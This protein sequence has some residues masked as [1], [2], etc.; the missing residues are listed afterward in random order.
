M[1]AHD[2]KRAEVR[3][4]RIREY[5]KNDALE[6]NA[7]LERLLQQRD[8]RRLLWWLL[9]IGRVS[10]QPFRADPYL[11]AFG[12]GEMNVGNQIQA[13]IIEASPTGYMNMQQEHADDD[14]TR[15]NSI[16]AGE[17]DPRSGGSPGGYDNPDFDDGDDTVE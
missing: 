11:T 8:G 15:S 1:A 6:I 3:E 14:R 12:C 16:N 2:D 4:R 17:R 9:E 7:A 10:G 5:A 13:R